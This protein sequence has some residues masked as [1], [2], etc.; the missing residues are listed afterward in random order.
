VL[1]FINS[2]S[3]IR[4]YYLSKTTNTTP[5]A[6]MS[7]FIDRQKGKAGTDGQNDHRREKYSCLNDKFSL[8][9]ALIRVTGD[10]RRPR[11]RGRGSAIQPLTSTSKKEKENG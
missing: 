7:A 3:P 11:S 8:P 10:G 6:P 1:I 2:S 9:F 4:D 5:S